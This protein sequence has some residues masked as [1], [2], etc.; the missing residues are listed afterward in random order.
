MGARGPAPK[1]STE[2]MGHPKPTTSNPVQVPVGTRKP[3]WPAPKA[4]DWHEDAIRWYKSLKVSGQAKFYEP[5]DI[6]FAFFLAGQM[7]DYLKYDRKGAQMFSALLTGMSSLLN[8]EADRRR[9]QIELVRTD[10]VKEDPASV[11]MANYMAMLEKRPKA[12]EVGINDEPAE[13]AA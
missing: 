12:S 10:V 1:R 6:A 7:S 8:T 13:G 9:A 11:A 4:E 5:S 2:R 3:T